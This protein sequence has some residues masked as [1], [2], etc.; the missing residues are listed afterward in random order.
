MGRWFISIY[1][2][3]LGACGLAFTLIGLLTIAYGTG[4]GDTILLTVVA[5]FGVALPFLDL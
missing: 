1:F 2:W 4:L 5:L 3:L